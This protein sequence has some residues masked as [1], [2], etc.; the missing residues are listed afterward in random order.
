MMLV[1][2]MTLREVNRSA[3]VA[4]GVGSSVFRLLL[5]AVADLPRVALPV[6]RRCPEAALVHVCHRYR[7]YAPPPNPNVVGIAPAGRIKM[8]I[9]SAAIPIVISCGAFAFSIF[10]WRERRN[11]DQRDLFLK[12]H[13]RLIDVDL[14]RGRRILAEN[15]H[16]V[17][18]AEALLRGS[19]ADYELANR[20]LAMFDIF[21]LYAERGYVD[22]KLV[23][24]EWG[25]TLANTWACGQ[26]LIAERLN[27]HRPNTWSAWPHFQK[28]GKLADEWVSSE[29]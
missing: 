5:D 17:K 18:D 1:A 16:S 2:E 21:A 12:M 8:D 19:P 29:A 25:Y 26:Y 7:K 6:D 27:R 4:S 14:Q 3:A 9:A 11:Q 20:A 13:E 22:R 10:T 24:E 23:L 28:L 15:I